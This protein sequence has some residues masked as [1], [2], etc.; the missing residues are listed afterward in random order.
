VLD[1]PVLVAPGEGIADGLIVHELTIEAAEDDRVVRV[2][3]AVG[4]ND[5][6]SA[7]VRELDRG[8]EVACHGQRY[9]LVAPD[10]AAAGAAGPSGGAV[11]APMPG[12]VLEVR[13]SADQQ[14]A[15]GD[16][17]GVMEA[18]KMEV[19]LKAPFDG[20][21]TNV[22]SAVG[23]QVALGARL[24]EVAARDSDEKGTH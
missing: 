9:V 8:V 23:D 20:I 19:T 21:V 7:F 16:I 17:L 2:E 4:T 6:V 15:E 14:V 18:M 24:F 1:R 10:R 3:A 22:A 12:T 5:R 11:L 13:V